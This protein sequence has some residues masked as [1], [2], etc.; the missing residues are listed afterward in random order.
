M[1]ALSACCSLPLPDT[2]FCHPLQA[3]DLTLPD[4][5]LRHMPP[6]KYSE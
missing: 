1:H 2:P 4:L 5:Y 6:R 3:I